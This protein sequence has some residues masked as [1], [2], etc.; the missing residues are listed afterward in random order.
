VSETVEFFAE[1][2][3]AVEHHA[4]CVPECTVCYPKDDGE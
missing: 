3:G 4:P 1:A 2:S